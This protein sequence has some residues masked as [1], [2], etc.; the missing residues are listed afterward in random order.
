MLVR[1]LIDADVD[2]LDET[3]PLFENVNLSIS[4]YMR[5]VCKLIYLTVTRLDIAYV[6]ESV[7]QFMHKLR[8]IY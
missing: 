2:L 5:L 1:T 8:E 6:I 4:Q 3:R 7:S